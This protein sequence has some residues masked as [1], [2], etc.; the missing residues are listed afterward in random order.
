[1]RRIRGIFVTGTDT[2]VGKTT[3]TA[4]LTAALRAEGINAGVWKPVQSGVSPESGL[5]DAA[6]LLLGAGLA[7][8]PETVAPFSFRA[9]LSPFLAASQEGVTLTMEALA[10]A[11]EPLNSRY[12]ALLVEGAGGVAVPL[13]EEA[14][15]SDF[16]AFLGIPAL[17]VARSGLGT[18]NHTLLT[19]EMLRKR[20][21]PII[22]VVLND[23][24]VNH[25][26]G[27]PSVA[28][29]AALIERYGDVKV[30]GHFPRVPV[31]NNETLRLT[32]RDAIDL[33]PVRLAL[34][35]QEMGG[36]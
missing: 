9:P 13:T 3:V 11:G 8:R 15:V 25:S 18:I 21:I 22:G 24:P 34:E 10:A 1:M 35:S 28:A 30:L 4:A 26:S 27:D 32:A 31:E 12:D 20:S 6:R 33:L 17:I 5:S 14:L 7:D 19:I 36:N 29:N 2:G 16:I 23:S